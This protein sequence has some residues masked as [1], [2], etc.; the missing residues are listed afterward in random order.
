MTSSACSLQRKP[1]LLAAWAGL[2]TLLLSA[3]ALGSPAR[4]E[5]L[6]FPSPVAIV[7]ASPPPLP[8]PTATIPPPPTPTSPPPTPAPKPLPVESIGAIGAWTDRLTD[9]ERWLGFLDLAVGEAALA[10]RSN[11]NPLLIALAQAQAYAAPPSDLE[12]LRNTRPEWL[13]YDR[14]R[15]PALASA[16]GQSPLLDIRNEFVRNFLAERVAQAVARG[17]YQ[18]ALVTNVGD[19]LIRTNATP[20]FTGT[21]AFTENERRDAVEQLLRVLRA[22]LPDKVLIISGYAWRDG[23]AYAAHA[24]AAQQLATFADGVHIEAF[25]R[26][27]ISRTN[28]FKPEAA[29]KRDIDFLSAISQDNKIVLVSTRLPAEASAEDK[30]RWLRYSVASFLLG[31]NGNRTYFQFDAGDPALSADPYLSAAPGAPTAAYTKLPSGAYAREFTNALVLVNPTSEQK[32]IT[33]NA[34]YRTPQGTEVESAVTMG[35][36]T[37]LILM[38]K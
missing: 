17:P 28:E 11:K 5:E 14:N 18:G 34:A 33:L 19:D 37:G 20:V 9:A 23:A 38:K 30:E 36:F 25:L 1:R 8:T 24:Q 7:P 21:R 26:A 16:D 12:M 27:P 35:P 10:Y 6:A 29:W 31:R 32:R 4:S 22:R 13:L 15:R 3:C 2:L